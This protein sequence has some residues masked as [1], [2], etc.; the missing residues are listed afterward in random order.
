MELTNLMRQR[1]KD[2]GDWKR[3]QRGRIGG[4]APQGQVSGRQMG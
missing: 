1:A 3:I 2:F 4:D